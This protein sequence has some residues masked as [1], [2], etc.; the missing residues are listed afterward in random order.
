MYE[1]L[2]YRSIVIVMVMVITVSRVC[3]THHWDWLRVVGLTI[4]SVASWTLI[5]RSPVALVR[6][7]VWTES[8]HLARRDGDLSDT[9]N[10]RLHWNHL[11]L[12]ILLLNLRLA[13]LWLVHLH[14]SLYILGRRVLWLVHLAVELIVHHWLHRLLL[15]LHRL[16]RLLLL[17]VRV[18]L[19]QRLLRLVLQLYFSVSMY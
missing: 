12:S 2:R 16:H 17:I 19:L 5:W 9:N 13:I 11:R 8:A 15:I 14:L 6:C 3:L 7:K 1:Y 10:Y 4:K 18:H